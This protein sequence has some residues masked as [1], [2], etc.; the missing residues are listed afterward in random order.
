MLPLV[1]RPR[2]YSRLRLSA[3]RLDSSKREVKLIGLLMRKSMSTFLLA[4]QLANSLSN[5]YGA[6][7]HETSGQCNRARGAYFAE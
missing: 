6:P 1:R 3:E 7:A 2:N 4:V 5:I